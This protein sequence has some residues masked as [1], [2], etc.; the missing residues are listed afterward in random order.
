MLVGALVVSGCGR[1]AVSE[2]EVRERAEEIAE[3]LLSAAEGVPRYQDDFVTSE[4]RQVE[5]SASDPWRYW[6]VD[7]TLVLAHDTPTSPV[8]VAEEMIRLLRADGWVSGSRPDPGGAG[9][10]T[11]LSK[12][13][14]GGSWIVS[15]VGTG[16]EPPRPQMVF[17]TVVS[18]AVD[19]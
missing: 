12:Q 18:S 11:T 19:H 3:L 6:Q 5:I 4:T 1:S 17:L 7:A 9:V 14:V 8:Q 10:D 13:D 15:L 16:L 2:D